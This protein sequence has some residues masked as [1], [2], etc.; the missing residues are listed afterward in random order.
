MQLSVRIT[1]LLDTLKLEHTVENVAK[2]LD[3]VV[4]VLDA[5]TTEEE[6]I[7]LYYLTHK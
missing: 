3:I 7:N 1:R 5:Y 6:V 4:K 2:V